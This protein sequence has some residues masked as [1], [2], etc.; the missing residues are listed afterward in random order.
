[1]LSVL[2]GICIIEDDEYEYLKIRE[3]SDFWSKGGILHTIIS[4]YTKSKDQPIAVKIEN[5][6]SVGSEL[7]NVPVMSLSNLMT[8]GWRD[9]DLIKKKYEWFHVDLFTDE[10]CWICIPGEI[11]EEVGCQYMP[12]GKPL[13]A[14]CNYLY[15]MQCKRKNGTLLQF[16]RFPTHRNDSWWLNLGNSFSSGTAGKRIYGVL[17]MN[18]EKCK[19]FDFG[20]FSQEQNQILDASMPR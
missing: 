17:D 8:V 6:F 18:I 11:T 15:G 12:S 4:A 13:I 10:K 19:P 20:I 16:L 5:T 14:N 9:P 2:G 7:S 3:L 1:M